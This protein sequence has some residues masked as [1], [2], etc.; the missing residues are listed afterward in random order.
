MLRAHT[1]TYAALR[2]LADITD[3]ADIHLWLVVHAE[4]L[5]S[6][7]AQLLEGLPHDTGELD[8]LLEQ[9]PRPGR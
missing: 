1:L 8:R 9:T 4:R 6:P 3:V 5:P 2:R 7:L